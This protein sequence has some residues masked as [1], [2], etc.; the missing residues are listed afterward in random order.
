VRLG[1]DACAHCR[2]TIVSLATA[3]QI[4]APGAEPVFFDDLGCLEAF[5]LA[6]PPPEGAVVFVMDSQS[7]EWIDAREATFI[8]TSQHT[9]MGSGL[10]AVRAKPKPDVTP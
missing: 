3:A 5:K 1:E 4:V 9:P 8:S 6:A 7:S 2:M 10:V